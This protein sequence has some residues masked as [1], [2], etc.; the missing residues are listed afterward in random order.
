MQEN[1]ELDD[2][3]AWYEPPQEMSN[4]IRRGLLR[5]P[6]RREE[7]EA[8]LFA[9]GSDSD[10]EDLFVD[11]PAKKKRVLEK[12]K[13]EAC[14][15]VGAE[16]M[17]CSVCMNPVFQ[18]GKTCIPILLECQHT[19]CFECFTKWFSVKKNGFDR[20]RRH[21]GVF[22]P[23]MFNVQCMVCARDIW[24]TNGMPSQIKLLIKNSAEALR[25]AVSTTADC[26]QAPPD[27]K[28]EMEY[29]KNTCQSKIP[30]SELTKRNLRA[31][32]CV[33]CKDNFIIAKPE[34]HAESQP[35]TECYSCL[36]IMNDPRFGWLNNIVA[37]DQCG[38]ENP[39]YI[40]RSKACS[41]VKCPRC[42][43]EMCSVCGG[44]YDYC[45]T[46]D[47]MRVDTTP[48]CALPDPCKIN[49]SGG[50]RKVGMCLCRRRRQE[51]ARYV[52]KLEYSLRLAP[53][54]DK[55]LYNV[56]SFATM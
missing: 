24:Y 55:V 30:A 5:R 48:Y 54:P 43:F 42:Q 27:I 25:S 29:F 52:G 9:L 20:V 33:K 45:V 51:E 1:V 41:H 31:A 26:D 21:G 40:Q 22:D 53:E 28:K 56:A 12:Q 11:P 16:S 35:R 10:D 18:K 47:T 8:L 14:E 13:E 23:S 2:D 46:F 49:R 38:D 39:T 15:L 6:S 34:C 37:C 17:T 32:C 3:F 19:Y 44:E 4:A 50:P 36:S 7:N